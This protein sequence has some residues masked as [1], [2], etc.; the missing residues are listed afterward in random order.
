[1]TTWSVKYM[2]NSEVFQMDFGKAYGLLL[3]C[4]EGADK[5]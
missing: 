3:D 5:S 4:Q 2:D 1:M